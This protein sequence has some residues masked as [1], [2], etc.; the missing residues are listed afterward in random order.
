MAVSVQR[1]FLNSL[2]WKFCILIKVSHKFVPEGIIVNKSSF[3]QVMACECHVFCEKALP[4]PMLTKIA[5]IIR[6][7]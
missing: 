6:H 4:V 1:L 5:V 2:E 7:S 3:V